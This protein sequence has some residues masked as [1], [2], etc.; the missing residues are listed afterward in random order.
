VEP[1]GLTRCWRSSAARRS[2]ST[3]RRRPVG[4]VTPR[5][6]G[7]VF[8][9]LGGEGPTSRWE[10]PLTRL[11]PPD[12]QCPGH[13]RRTCTPRR[14][15]IGRA[16]HHD[17]DRA[18]GRRRGPDGLGSAGHQPRHREVDPRGPSCCATLGR[19]IREGSVRALDVAPGA[20]ALLD[21]L[22]S[23]ADHQ[24]VATTLLTHLRQGGRHVGGTWRHEDGPGEGDEECTRACLQII[25]RV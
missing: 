23:R 9:G 2:G 16:G 6:A 12:V 24:R 11:S 20:H 25:T 1:S 22:H 17:Q 5:A 3:L 21:G 13:A 14:S 8:P 10:A 15:R 18:C 19:P 4:L 7:G